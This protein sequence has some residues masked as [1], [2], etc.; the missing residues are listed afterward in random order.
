[1][2]KSLTAI[3]Q[4][5]KSLKLTPT[6]FHP[7]NDYEGARMRH[8]FSIYICSNLSAVEKQSTNDKSYQRV[9]VGGF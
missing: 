5:F 3:R 8:S 4:M 9:V 6:S 1:M 7:R 2:R